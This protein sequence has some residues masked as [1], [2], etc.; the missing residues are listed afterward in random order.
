MAIIFSMGKHSVETEVT[1]NYPS[2]KGPLSPL[3]CGEHDLRRYSTSEKRCIACK[4]RSDVSSPCVL[5]E[6]RAKAWWCAISLAAQLILSSLDQ[7]ISLPLHIAPTS[8]TTSESSRKWG[9][10][11]STDCSQPR[12]YF[13]AQI[14][15][16]IAD[17]FIHS[18]SYCIQL[19]RSG[20]RLGRDGRLGF[21]GPCVQFTPL[22]EWGGL[23]KFVGEVDSLVVVYVWVDFSF[24]RRGF[25]FLKMP[26]RHSEAGWP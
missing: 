25:V 9:S 15:L 2:E 7:T 8:Y 11:G 14:T 4:L 22:L 12:S 3:F 19:Y 23:M 16:L 21:V 10:L 26:L 13:Q 24:S 5:Y 1:I 6:N 17:V 18:K 20:Q